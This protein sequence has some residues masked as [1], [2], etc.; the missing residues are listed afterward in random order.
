MVLVSVCR[1]IQVQIARFP[2]APT[3]AMVMGDVN[4]IDDYVHVCL[5]G[6]VLIVALHNA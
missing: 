2:R 6:Q 1:T 4:M 5:D 3:F